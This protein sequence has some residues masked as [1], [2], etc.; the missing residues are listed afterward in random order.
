MLPGIAG[1]ADLDVVAGNVE[2]NAI[3]QPSG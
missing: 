3:H 1:L 2:D